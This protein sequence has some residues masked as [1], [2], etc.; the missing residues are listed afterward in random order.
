MY[1]FSL[2]NILESAANEFFLGFTEN[3]EGGGAPSL[4]LF[5]TTPEPNPVMFDIETLTG[6]SFSGVATNNATTRVTL[7]SDLQ[8]FSNSTLERNKGIRVRAEEGR[9]IVV[10]G[11]N[12]FSTTSDAFVALPCDRL[13]V[14][15]YEYYAISYTPT[16]AILPSTVLLV[17]CEDNTTVTTNSST[18]TLNQL[19]TFLMESTA[20]D[21]TGTRIVTNKPI[22]FFPGHECSFVPSGIRACD[23]LTEQVPPTAIWGRFFLAASFLGRTSGEIFRILASTGATEVVMNCT[24]ESQPSSFTLSSAG[25]WVEVRISADSFCSIESSNSILVF[26]FGLGNDLDSVGDPFMTMI[27]P[28]EQYGNNYVFSVLSDFST[29]FITVHVAPEFFQPDRI[30]VDNM[31]L[32]TSSFTEVY[33]TGSVICGFITRIP[34]PPGEHRLFHQDANANIG[35]VAYGFNAFNSYGYP[36]GLQLIPIQRKWYSECTM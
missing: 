14:D 26:E 21:L 15:E 33:C 27:P 17:G 8:V 3:D 4:L 32:Q 13:P 22:S 11:L 31:S 6:F 36:G 9:R 12:F 35:V 19:E 34:L 5:V 28:V 25:S 20:N 29:N 10:Y 23:H 18:F 7:P 24:T 1:L 30:F 2:G 16:L